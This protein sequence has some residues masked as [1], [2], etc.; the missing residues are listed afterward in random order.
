MKIEGLDALNRPGYTGD[1]K[2]ATWNHRV[3]RRHKDGV[4]WLEITEVH[5]RDFKPTTFAIEMGTPSAGGEG[6]ADAECLAELAET[7]DRMKAAL[8]K[9]ILDEKDFTGDGD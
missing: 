5:Y 7:L 1:G 9:P 2:R 3:V 4:S 8:A 6:E